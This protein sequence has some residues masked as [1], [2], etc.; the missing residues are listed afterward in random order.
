MFLPIVVLSVVSMRWAYGW[1]F[2]VNKILLP[3]IVNSY[4]IV[5]MSLLLMS[6][7]TS[8]RLF[9]CYWLTIT[10]T[11]AHVHPR[12]KHNHSNRS[13]CLLYISETHE[14]R[15]K[16]LQGKKNTNYARRRKQTSS[17]NTSKTFSFR[18]FINYIVLSCAFVI[19]CLLV[20]AFEW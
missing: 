12:S 19:I 18:K 17:K 10:V 2:N 5:R 13:H 6:H 3:G 16:H 14:D 15:T 4:I 11:N 7:Q 8:C 1:V 20:I 9:R